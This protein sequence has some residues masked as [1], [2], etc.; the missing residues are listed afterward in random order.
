MANRIILRIEI[1]PEAKT[2]LQ[3]FSDRAGMTQFAVTSR[4]VEW[5]GAQ[6]EAVQSAVLRRYP[7]E[8]Q[9]DVGKMILKAMAA[10][11]K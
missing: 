11:K 6:P 1:T 7:S 9:A 5:F 10:G 4:L 8:I 2:A 3:D